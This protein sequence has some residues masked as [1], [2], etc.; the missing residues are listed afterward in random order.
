MSHKKNLYGNVWK[1][2]Q[3][4]SNKKMF[5]TYIKVAAGKKVY[6]KER[7]KIRVSV[8]LRLFIWQQDILVCTAACAI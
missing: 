4:L 5:W 8:P 6:K 3:Q 1:N 2:L 7:K